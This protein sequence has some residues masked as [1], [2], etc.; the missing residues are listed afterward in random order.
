MKKLQAEAHKKNGQLSVIVSVS[1]KKIELALF[2]ELCRS[3]SN[4]S[5]LQTGPWDGGDLSPRVSDKVTL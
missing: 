5:L 2:I 3:S 1:Q 4:K